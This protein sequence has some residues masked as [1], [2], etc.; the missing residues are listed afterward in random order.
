MT[1]ALTIR[2]A[3]LDDLPDLLDLYTHLIVD[4]PPCP[5]ERA[6]AQFDRLIALDGATVLLGHVGGQLVVSCVL[7]IVP[8][9]TRGGASFAM[10]ENVVTHAAFRGRGFGTCILD[11]ATELG[12]AGGCYKIM[13]MTGSKR[14]S[15]LSFYDSA[16]FSRTKTAFEKRSVPL[17][18]E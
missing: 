3:G 2:A 16:G 4:E 9:L 5:P 7:V 12:Q 8:N 1:G 14:P 11:A 15:T 13:L 6:R 10:I 17:R 18:K